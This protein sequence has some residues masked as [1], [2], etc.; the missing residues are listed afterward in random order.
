MRLGS[1]TVYFVT[2]TEDLNNRDILGNPETVRVKV[3]VRGCRFRPMTA[4]EEIDAPAINV[5]DI[6]TDP[7]R[8]TAPPTAT[9]MAA[10]SNDEVEVDGITYQIVG[11]PRVFPGPRGR[12]FKVTII[13]QRM[14]G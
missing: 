5:G 2:V 3:P 7:W 11:G 14:D 9:V 1:Q 12:P 8:C 6:V 10:K 13:C 4:K